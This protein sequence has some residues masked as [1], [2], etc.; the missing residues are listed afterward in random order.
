MVIS[1]FTARFLRLSGQMV[2]RAK[3]VVS[4]GVAG[5]VTLAIY[6]RSNLISASQWR[7]CGVCAGRGIEIIFP[8]W[9]IVR[10]F[11]RPSI[12]EPF[13]RRRAVWLRGNE[14]QWME[15]VMASF[16]F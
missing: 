7:P 3:M 6:A 15:P 2:G 11:D 13:G 1:E 9:L 12:D 10:G 16:V 5:Y 14:T 4:S 8:V